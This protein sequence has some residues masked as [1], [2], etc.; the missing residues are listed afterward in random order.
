LKL[1]KP[2]IT[3]LR[4]LTP[5]FDGPMGKREDDGVADNGTEHLNRK[6]QRLANLLGLVGGVWV[7]GALTYMLLTRLSY[8][9]LT[10]VGK[11]IVVGICLS[12]VAFVIS[13]IWPFKGQ[14][15]VQRGDM[16]DFWSFVRGPEPEVPYKKGLWRKMRRTVGIW[17]LLAAWMIIAFIAGVSGLLYR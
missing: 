1:T 14:E 15:L 12:G 17:F 11:S 2:S 16:A 4:S 9:A 5:V 10:V 6:R 13:A 7:A 8:P 3:E